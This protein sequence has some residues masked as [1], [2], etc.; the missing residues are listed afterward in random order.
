MTDFSEREVAVLLV[1][2]CFPLFFFDFDDSSSSIGTV[3]M[4]QNNTQQQQG[5]SLA[6]KANHILVLYLTMD[7]NNLLV[8][9]LISS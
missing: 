2:E 6:M 4:T 9:G 3:P 7:I 1:F 8:G 5:K